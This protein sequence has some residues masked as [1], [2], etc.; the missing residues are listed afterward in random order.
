MQVQAQS[1]SLQTESTSVQGSVSSTV[2]EAVPDVNHNPFYFA[3][4]LPGVVAH[5]EQLS[6]MT[7]YSFG[8]GMYSRDRL[9]A[10][11]VNGTGR[12]LRP[13]MNQICENPAAFEQNVN[14]NMLKDGSR[15]WIAWTNKTVFDNKGNLIEVMSIGTDITDRKQAEE[16]LLKNARLLRRA[17]EVAKFGSWEFLMDENRVHASEGARAIYGLETKDWYISDVR[18]IPLKAYQPMLERAMKDLIELGIPYNVE[19][20]ICRPTDGKIIDI[21]SIAEYNSTKNIVFGV[22]QDITEHKRAEKEK[23]TLQTQLLQAQKM[24]SVGRLAGGVAHDFNNNL[25]A[26]IG[27]GKISL[28]KMAI[29]DPMRPNI[30]Q[31]LEAVRTGSTS[32]HR[33]SFFQQ[34]AASQ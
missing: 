31:I 13:L 28:M 20:K 14:E 34:K 17:E 7:A 8:V 29:G 33:S 32:N 22:I 3:T 11:S 2:I 12:D 30:E 5:D 26:I 10:F 25:T 27:Y 24:E 9:S 4:L 19:F 18:N 23:D 16:V 6:S 1:L 15:V 21:H